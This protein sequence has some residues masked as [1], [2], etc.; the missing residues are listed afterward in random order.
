M[1]A[2]SFSFLLSHQLSRGNGVQKMEEIFSIYRGRDGLALK[3]IYQLSSETK[4]GDKPIQISWNGFG[5]DLHLNFER[6][7]KM[8]LNLCYF[9]HLFLIL[10]LTFCSK[11]QLI[12]NQ[13]FFKGN[14]ILYNFSRNRENQ[15][16]MFSRPKMQFKLLLKVVKFFEHFSFLF[17][18]RMY[19]FLTFFFFLEYICFSIQLVFQKLSSEAKGGDKPIR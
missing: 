12:R 15:V 9:L 19:L 16:S 4:G 8:M 2:H 6:K 11:F 18:F 1:V 10:S 7:L 5:V 17:F 14:S 13:F 3:L